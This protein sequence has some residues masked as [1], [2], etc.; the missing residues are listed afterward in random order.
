MNSLPSIQATSR[1]STNAKLFTAFALIFL[2]TAP[3]LPSL[4][5]AQRSKPEA[6]DA[7]AA[8]PAQTE[9]G[10]RAEPEIPQRHVLAASYYSLKNKLSATLMLNN[11]SPQ[12]MDARLTLFSLGGERLEVPAV[13]VEGVSHR[14][15]D[16]RDYASAG[17]AF[18]EG[19]LQ[20]VYYG[21]PLQM[22]A[23]VSLVDAEHSL[24]SD[25]Q[26]TY[27]VQS[28]SARRSGVWR[29]PSRT[30][31]VR[32]VL[33]NVSN[34]QI[35]INTN[36][37]RQPALAE[38]QLTL[39]SHETRVVNLRESTRDKGRSLPRSAALALNTRD[40]RVRSWRGY[41]FRKP[42]RAT[43]LWLNS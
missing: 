18:E 3:F 6:G 27:P 4:S 24:I 19:S 34:E 15:V 5:S 26:L 28:A 13:T 42:R 21:K 37:D 43:L 7:T 35:T 14:M 2:F 29:L 17:S 38:G 30:C 11:K 25:E 22:G 9:I 39:M 40:L 8:V 23:Q 10:D 32:L 1:K 33:S 16:L 36:A 12:P 41:S 31:D 20:V